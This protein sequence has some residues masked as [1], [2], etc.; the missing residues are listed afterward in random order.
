MRNI[1]EYRKC[2]GKY[3]LSFLKI[4]ILAMPHSMWDLSFPARDEP[5]HPTVETW[6][7]N[8]WTTR[9][10]TDNIFSSVLYVDLTRIVNIFYYVIH[11]MVIKLVLNFSEFNLFMDWEDLYIRS[12]LMEV[13][14]L[15]SSFNFLVF[16]LISFNHFKWYHFNCPLDLYGEFFLA[17][18]M[19]LRFWM[20]TKWW[21]RKIFLLTV[22]DIRCITS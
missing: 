6:R 17:I 20:K 3:F 10:V 7:L 2:I 11:T 16:W 1:Y 22:Y 12:S 19:I 21:E 18:R 5:E 4:Y 13:N 8:H 15:Y 14:S 9:E